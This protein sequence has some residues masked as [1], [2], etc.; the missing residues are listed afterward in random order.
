M[1]AAA[2]AFVLESDW[3]VASLGVALAG[4]SVLAFFIKALIRQSESRI[5]TSI[6]K[7][8]T[9]LA[10]LA[11]RVGRLEHQVD[12]TIIPKQERI[13]RKLDAEDTP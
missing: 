2:A 1:S 6:G 12:E 5:E 13:A 7:L 3:V 11:D 9:Q 8:A 10:D 4:F